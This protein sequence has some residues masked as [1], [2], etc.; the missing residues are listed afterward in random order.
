MIVKIYIQHTFL[1]RIQN[2]CQITKLPLF[3]KYFISVAKF[4]S[5]TSILALSFNTF[6]QFF[7]VTKKLFAGILSFIRIQ[8]KLHVAS[9][10]QLHRTY[11]SLFQL[12]KPRSHL[13]LFSMLLCFDRCCPSACL[14]ID[15]PQ[16]P[17]KFSLFIFKLFRILLFL[18]LLVFLNILTRTYILVLLIVLLSSRSDHLFVFLVLLV[19]FPN[20]I[21]IIEPIL[22]LS[23]PSVSS[24]FAFIIILIFFF[25]VVIVFS[26]ISNIIIIV[27][28]VVFFDV[29]RVRFVII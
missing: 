1:C 21:I 3:I 10:H 16:I 25:F 12:R 7:N 9:L 17:F 29:S 20:L 24:S 11:S 6:T 8:I 22:I 13:K 5:V 28:I 18:L 19:S 14:S 27:V 2:F 4:L 15:I 23:K 26:L